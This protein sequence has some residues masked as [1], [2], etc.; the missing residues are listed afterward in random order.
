MY[1]WFTSKTSLKQARETG[2]EGP[3]VKGRLSFLAGESTVYWG[4]K[5]FVKLSFDLK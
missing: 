4:F 2:G 5:A 1:I 3:A